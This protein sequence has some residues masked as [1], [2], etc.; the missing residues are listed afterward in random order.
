MIT[1]RLLKTVSLPYNA[2]KGSVACRQY[3]AEQFTHRV[4][5]NISGQLINHSIPFS[6]FGRLLKNFLPHNLE[7]FVKKNTASDSFA[8]LRRFFS[9]DIF[10]NKQSI[11]LIPEKN[12]SINYLCIPAL[13]HEIRHLADSLF[14]SKILSRE[15]ILAQKGLDT[16]KY[17]HFYDTEVYTKEMFSGKKDKKRILKNL[18]NKT[19]NVLKRLSVQDKID[20]LQEMR[21]SLMSEKYAYKT[22]NKYAKKLYKKNFEIYQDDTIDYTKIYMF[23]EKIKLYKNMIFELIKKARGIHHAKLNK[24][25]FKTKGVKD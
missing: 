25:H 18:R 16:Y 17:T 9:K 5:N 1:G 10:I 20:L 7:I 15:Q 14:H 6:I 21:Y 19:K 3:K 2:V 11:E 13:A 23:D 8:Q 4:I 24:A 22:G 12:N